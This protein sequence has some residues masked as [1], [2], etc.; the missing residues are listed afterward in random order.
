MAETAQPQKRMPGWCLP[1]GI[2]CGV[3]VLLIVGGCGALF[4]VGMKKIKELPPYKM[5]L[6][7]V[8]QNEQAVEALGEP[9]EGSIAMQGDLKDT[10]LVGNADLIIPISGPKGKGSMFVTAIEAGGIWQIEALS[11]QLEDGTIIEI[12][13]AEGVPPEEPPAEP[14]PPAVPPVDTAVG[15]EP[16]V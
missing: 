11:V 9:I 14:W 15:A 12:L 10:G 3:V 13:P 5:S 7:L 2:G 8:R 1:V 6:D 16:A 4:L